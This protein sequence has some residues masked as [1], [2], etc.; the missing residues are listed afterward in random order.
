MRETCKNEYVRKLSF[1]KP[2]YTFGG[3]WPP[4]KE[5]I[6]RS[7]GGRL[8]VMHLLTTDGSTAKGA[9]HSFKVGVL[10]RQ[11]GTRLPTCMPKQRAVSNPCFI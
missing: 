7:A 10:Q 1:G 6:Y 3:N 2:H 11:P 9:F 4:H 5:F 8:I